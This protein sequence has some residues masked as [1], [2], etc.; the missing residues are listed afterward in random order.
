MEPYCTTAESTISKFPGSKHFRKWKLLNV[1]EFRENNAFLP[2]VVYFPPQSLYD[3]QM[4]KKSWCRLYNVHLKC[5]NCFCVRI[6]INEKIHIFYL[7]TAWMQICFDYGHL[8]LYS[9][10]RT[11]NS[12][13]HI[14]SIEIWGY[15]M[16]SKPKWVCD[17][18]KVAHI[19]GGDP[20]VHW[21]IQNN[22]WQLQS[23]KTSQ[24]G[25]VAAIPSGGPSVKALQPG[26]HDHHTLWI[27]GVMVKMDE[28]WK[29]ICQHCS[30]TPAVHSEGP[31]FSLPLFSNIRYLLTYNWI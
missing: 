24:W 5:C 8:S 6:P 23:R 17:F 18:L 20:E 14:F 7:F 15:K 3:R 21:T 10:K 30:R 22:E 2:T 12:I 13:L 19:V 29:D 25:R 27:W 1:T 11:H 16:G 9:L 4:W 31:P 28:E 26:F